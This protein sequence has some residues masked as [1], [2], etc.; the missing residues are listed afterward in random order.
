LTSY[1]DIGYFPPLATRKLL[2]HIPN[3]TPRKERELTT[4]TAAALLQATYKDIEE[5]KRDPDLVI[6][7]GGRFAAEGK[8]SKTTAHYYAKE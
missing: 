6:V 5:P 1:L 8:V 7:S 4:P 2:S 3:K